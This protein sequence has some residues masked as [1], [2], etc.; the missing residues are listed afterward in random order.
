VSNTTQE[1]VSFVQTKGGTPA[2]TTIQ[3]R[4]ASSLPQA[5]F[6]GNW[7]N[8]RF[9]RCLE[10]CLWPIQLVVTVL[11]DVKNDEKEVVTPGASNSRQ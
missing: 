5:N 3:S 8:I 6:M 4:K 1:E 10:L 2:T 9:C 7:H 11:R